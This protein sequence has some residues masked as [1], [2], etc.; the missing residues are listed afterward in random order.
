MALFRAIVFLVLF[1]TSVYQFVVLTLY[2]IDPFDIFGQEVHQIPI[3]LSLDTDP[4]T[5]TQTPGNGSREVFYPRFFQKFGVVDRSVLG[6][7]QDEVLTLF[8]E[9]EYPPFLP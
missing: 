3:G 2:L 4:A 8:H 7:E 5:R 1:F 6:K 9:A